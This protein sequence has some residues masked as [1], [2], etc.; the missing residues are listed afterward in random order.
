MY[1]NIVTY[2]TKHTVRGLS[3]QAGTVTVII[4]SHKLTAGDV[5]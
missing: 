3:T 4:H 2:R 5:T 1:A